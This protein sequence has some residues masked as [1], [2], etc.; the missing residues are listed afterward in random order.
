MAVGVALATLAATVPGAGAAITVG[1]DLGRAPDT[2]VCGDMF[3]EQSC[4]L[5]IAGLTAAEDA[6]GGPIVPSNGVV[7]RWRV[8]RAA[9]TFTPEIHLRVIRGT[10]GAGS[11]AA[12]TLP[13]AAGT[14]EFPTRLPVL[15]GDQLGLDV[16]GVPASLLPPRGIEVVHSGTA[17]DLL[18][19]W[20]PPLAEGVATTPDPD[21]AD[22]MELTINADIEPDADFDGFGDETQD[23]C[24]TSPATQAACVTAAPD[25]I[26]TKAPKK[27]STKTKATVEFTSN[28]VGAVF[29]CS[30]DFVAFRDCVSPLRLTR[31]HKGK[32]SAA[33]ARDRLRDPR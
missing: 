13:A 23:L 20:I 28:P 2:G 18:D 31:L 9:Q 10:T 8:R 27:K 4:T 16:I 5:S 3:T 32:T 1:S 22:S 26:I 30:L 33:R 11:S 14:Y 29:Q 19:T 24:P 17:G 12:A 6:A 25:T 21:N 7:V 15:A